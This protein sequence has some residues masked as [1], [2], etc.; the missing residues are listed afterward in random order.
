MWTH[1]A[2]PGFGAGLRPPC[3]NTTC[4]YVNIHARRDLAVVLKLRTSGWEPI[5]DYRGSQCGHRGPYKREAAGPTG[6]EM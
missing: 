5:L 3:P 2:V 4:E 6:G 1:Q